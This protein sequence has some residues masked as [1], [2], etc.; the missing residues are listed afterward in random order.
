MGVKMG[1][2]N[3]NNHAEQVLPNSSQNCVKDDNHLLKSQSL[4]LKVLICGVLS[5]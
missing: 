3:Q 2:N 4:R 5:Y 1:E